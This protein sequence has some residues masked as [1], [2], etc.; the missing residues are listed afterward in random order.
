[1][2]NILALDLATKTGWALAIDGKLT[3]SGVQDFSLKRGDSPGMRFVR[4]RSWLLEMVRLNPIG[5]V[6]YEQPHH[7]GGAATSVC[8][9]LEGHL[10]AVC[11]EKGIDHTNVTAKTIKLYAAGKGNASKDR[12][13]IEAIK[14]WSIEII[15]D[16]HADA[17]WIL[18][19]ALVFLT[20]NTPA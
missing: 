10:L 5:L 11:A 19:W 13:I 12:M 18:D 9:G 7:R 8:V 15:D 4:F 17:L 14:K 1:M 3:A 16:N 6:V 2:V 20:G